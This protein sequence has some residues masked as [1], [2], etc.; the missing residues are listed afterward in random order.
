ML[1]ITS[2]VTLIY[3]ND[4][5]IRM[6]KNVLYHVTNFTLNIILKKSSAH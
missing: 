5:Q 1:K 4:L 6:I 2:D 3:K